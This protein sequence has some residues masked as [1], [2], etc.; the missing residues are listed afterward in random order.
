MRLRV[1]GTVRVPGKDTVHTALVD[2]T[3]GSRNLPDAS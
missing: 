1:P 3:V 2:T